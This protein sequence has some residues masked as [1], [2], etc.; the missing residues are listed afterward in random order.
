MVS[1][2]TGLERRRLQ[3]G[4]GDGRAPCTR[5]GRHKP[6]SLPRYLAT[7]LPYLNNLFL[8]NVANAY[9][10]FLNVSTQYREQLTI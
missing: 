6:L 8:K 2:Y 4:L 9:D 7:G 10:S 5:P 1:I 3:I